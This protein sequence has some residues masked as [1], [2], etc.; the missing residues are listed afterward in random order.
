MRK[1]LLT[2]KTIAAIG[3]VTLVSAGAAAAATGT[4]P[5]P[6]ASDKAQEVTT[7]RVPDIARENVGKHVDDS[8]TVTETTLAVVVAPVDQTDANESRI[9]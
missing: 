2:A 9:G 5:S 1:K 3:A 8:S 7:E 4:V 6:F